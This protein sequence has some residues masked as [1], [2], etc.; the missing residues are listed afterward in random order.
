MK[1]SIKIL[2]AITLGLTIASCSGEAESTAESTQ[3]TTCTYSYNEGATNITWT[4]YKT[5]AKVPV[6][7]GFNEYTVEA[8]SGSD[9]KEVISSMTFVINTASVETNNPERN[10][11]IAEH[12]FKTI[13]TPEITG[14]V[15]SLNEDGTAVVSIAMNG[16]NFDT[17]GNYTLEGEKF[18]FSAT[19]D[20]SSW[21]GMAGI[22]ALNAV[23]KDLH[24]GEDGV[25]KLW[26]EVEISFETTLKSDCQ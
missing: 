6:G 9:L 12:F 4:A 25:S 7:G 1:R 20:V 5:S 10:A 17:K 24:T 11:K 22:E 14:N 26:S 13:Q 21:N 18:M 8:E 19:I 23:C 15:K 16:V 2:A 3:E